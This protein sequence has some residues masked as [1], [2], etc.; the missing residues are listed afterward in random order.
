MEVNWF[1]SFAKEGEEE[2][3]IDSLLERLS[4]AETSCVSK[5]VVDDADHVPLDLKKVKKKPLVVKIKLPAEDGRYYCDKLCCSS[6][7]PKWKNYQR[8]VRVVHGKKIHVCQCGKAYS[9]RCDLKRHESRHLEK[10]KK[11]GT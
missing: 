6:S 10:K 3:S 2:E 7:F 1:D 9:Q 4:N 11:K 5:E 8:H